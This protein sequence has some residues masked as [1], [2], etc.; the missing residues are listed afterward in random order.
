[1]RVG[2]RLAH[3]LTVLILSTFLATCL[4]EVVPGDPTVAIVGETASPEVVAQVRHELRLDENVVVRYGYWLSDAVTGDLGY[5]YRTRQDITQVIRDRVPVTL[6][7]GVLSVL[8]ALVV[9]IPVG[10]Y[11][12]HRPGGRVDRI[13]SGLSSAALSA[14]G[15]LIALL[16]VY[17]FAVRW[18]LLP[19]TGWV[20]FSENPVEHV[21]HLLL[22]VL[23]LAVAEIAVFL[24]LLRADMI[25]TLQ[26]DYIL[27]AVAKGMTPRHVLFRNALR[28]SSFSLVTVSAVTL[29]RVIGGTVIV[30]YLFSLPGLGSYI[31]ESI[32]AKD[33]MAVQGVVAFIAATYVIINAVVEIAY[34]WLDP[35]LRVRKV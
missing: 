26:E 11:S 16:L 1:M 6:E 5:S 4:L 29:G 7:I 28:P 20:R 31:Y 8:V 34:N 32:F 10:I 30:E 12:A 15:F 21:R 19:V 13:V 18:K 17:A 2:K 9:A 14:P 25:A 33:I 27:A 22:P 35:R 23:S 24:R 3:L